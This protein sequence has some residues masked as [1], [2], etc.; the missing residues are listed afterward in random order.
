MKTSSCSRIP[1]IPVSKP[2]SDTLLWTATL[3][4]WSG[5]AFDKMAQWHDRMTQRRQLKDLDDRLLADIGVNRIDACNESAKP[6][7]QA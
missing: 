7:W 4:R 2:A 1:S 6:F 5:A 3:R